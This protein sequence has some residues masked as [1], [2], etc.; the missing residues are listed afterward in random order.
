MS[1][2][3]RHWRNTET[4]AVAREVA[5]SGRL[6]SQAKARVPKMGEVEQHYFK[7]YEHK[8]TPRQLLTHRVRMLEDRLSVLPVTVASPERERVDWRQVAEFL[9]DDGWLWERGW[10]EPVFV[11]LILLALT[12]VLATVVIWALR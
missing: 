11:R 6:H 1:V 9:L 12:L 2:G 3:T 5:R 10:A 4:E 7:R 8:P